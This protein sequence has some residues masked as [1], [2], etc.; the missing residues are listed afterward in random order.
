VAA[1]AL[2]VATRALGDG[3]AVQV[4][5]ADGPFLVT[6]FTAP[7]PLRAGSVD[8]GVLVQTGDGNQPVLDAEVSVTLTSSSDG[9]ATIHATATRQQATNKLLY[10]A[11]VN[12]P[13]TGSWDARV[14]VRR[15]QEV[16]EVGGQVTVA[17]A[18]PPLF[19]HWPYLAFPPGA[20]LIFT[21]HQWLRSRSSKAS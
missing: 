21:L 10:A 18:L 14:T 11:A 12:L 16:A 6:V 15:E 20:V 7:T 3:G 2:L 5:Q 8:I 17:A 19:S 4:R 9:T 1:L 13:F